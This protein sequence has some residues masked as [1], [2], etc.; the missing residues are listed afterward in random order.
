MLGGRV[1]LCRKQEV[2][3]VWLEVFCDLAA[4]ILLYAGI[5]CEISV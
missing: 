2:S 3:G 4:D 1:S 5:G